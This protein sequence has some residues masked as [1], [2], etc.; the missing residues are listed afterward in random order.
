M[1]VAKIY[2]ITAARI[3]KIHRS[4]LLA[5]LF[6]FSLIIN[7]GWAY[8]SYHNIPQDDPDLTNNLY[9]L[10]ALDIVDQG[11][12]WYETDM[13]YKDVVGPVMPWITAIAI[14]IFKNHWLG[15]FIF[16]GF[17]LSLLVLL[18]AKIALLLFDKAVA[19]L[20]GLWVSVSPLYLYFV[21]STGKDIWMSL[22]LLLIVYNYLLLFHSGRYSLAGFLRLIFIIVLSFHLDERFVLFGLVI[23]MFILLY[24]SKA[25]NRFSV[26]RPSVFILF[27]LVLMLPW[28]IRNYRKFDKPVI[29]TT[30]TERFSDLL[31]GYEHRANPVD[32][33][34]KLE[35]EM[36]I[37]D[38]QIDSVLTGEKKVTDFGY[39]ISEA[40]RQ[41]MLEG[42]LPGPLSAGE[43]FFSRLTAMF[44]PVQFRARWERSGY[45]FSKKSIRHNIIS[46]LFYGTILILSFYGA[47][48]LYGRDRMVFYLF[49]SLIISYALLHILFI[50]YTNWRYRLPLDAFFIIL[51]FFS[52]RHIFNNL[53]C[54]GRT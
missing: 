26:V 38:Y 30:R 31:L 15:I 43:S 53:F 42:N 41:F 48:L 36:Y 32:Q 19:L 34:Y 6:I 13:A 22:F 50:P 21:P 39:S 3:M 7:I 25:D 20:A 10:I 1:T 54:K 52:L 28:T 11:T 2:N 27:S 45:Y 49:L 33:A 16:S 14:Y 40:Q 29:L 44:S 47:Y 17:A 35:S 18:T 8:Y 5:G 12:F 46:L 24:G 37:Y 23:F 51:A 4:R 9:Y